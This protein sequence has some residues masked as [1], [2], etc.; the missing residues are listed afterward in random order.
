MAGW[1]CMCTSGWETGDHLLIHCAIALDLWNTVLRSFRVLWVFPDRIANLLFGWHNCF[2]KHNSEVWNLVPLCLMWTVWRERN[3]RTFEDEEHSNTKL[4]E[5]FFG[6]LFDWVQVWGF[7][8]EISLADFFV[9]LSFSFI[10]I[11]APL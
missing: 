11:S 8:S 5:L 3:R 1:Y 6:L 4:T 10:P 9:S 2:G 7:T